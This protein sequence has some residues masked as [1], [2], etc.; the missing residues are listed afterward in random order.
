[1]DESARYF[2]E[3]DSKSESIVVSGTNYTISQLESNEISYLQIYPLDVWGGKK[4]N[5]IPPILL[6]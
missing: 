6:V 1:M 4:H 2:L 5:Q 3:K